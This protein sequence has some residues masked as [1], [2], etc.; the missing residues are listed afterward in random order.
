VRLAFF[1]SPAFAL[2]SLEG[3]RAA[4]HEITLVV[5]QPNRPAGRGQ[6]TTPP[7]VAAYAIKHGLPLWQT[8]SLRGPEAEARLQAVGA[9]AMALAAF[10]ALVPSN[11]LEL[12]PGG[13]LNVHPSLLPR[14][15][16]AA[17]IQ[18]ALL[19]GDD[20][21]G[22]SIIRLVQALDA[23]PVLLQEQVPI[24]P[25][26]D[27][28]SLERSLAELGAQLLVRALE[29]RPEPRPQDDAAATFSKRISREDAQI[30]WT[31]PAETIWNQ[32][33]AYRGWPQAYT[34]FDGRIL[35]ILQAWPLDRGDASMPP[36]AASVDSTKNGRPVVATG[37]G[38]LRLHEVQ[39]EGRRAQS[40]EE[41]LRGYPGIV[42]AVLGESSS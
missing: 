26:D 4:G 38:W 29:E 18:S 22:V 30:D 7:A 24:A 12:S 14:W 11:V 32:V 2:P 42:G 17:P 36:G 34:T 6:K 5:T 8:S 16:G 39:L 33:R 13:I 37:S 20:T 9:E 27:Y 25:E 23:G 31:Q 3:L 10:A 21:T 41:F 15:R 40:G 1:G 35:K 19:A 28:V